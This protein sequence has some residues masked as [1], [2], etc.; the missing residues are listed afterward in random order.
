MKRDNKYTLSWS[1]LEA[2]CISSEMGTHPLEVKKWYRL[3]CYL[4]SCLGW[5]P[6]V[7]F[8]TVWQIR[9]FPL[10]ILL[11]MVCYCAFFY[12]VQYGFY[13]FLRAMNRKGKL[14]KYIEE[15]R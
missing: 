13:L 9:S 1:F 12:A 3:F 15:D 14:S 5:A 2:T 4:I 11:S 8:D 7:L 6:A 10:R